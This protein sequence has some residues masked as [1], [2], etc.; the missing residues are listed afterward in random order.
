MSALPLKFSASFELLYDLQFGLYCSREWIAVQCLFWTGTFL[1]SVFQKELDCISLRMCLY[2]IGIPVHITSLT[3]TDRNGAKKSLHLLEGN[4]VR[5]YRIWVWN[6][7]RAQQKCVCMVTPLM[8]DTSLC[9]HSSDWGINAGLQ[10]MWLCNGKSCTD[11]LR[12]VR[13]NS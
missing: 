12:K 11:P 6:G 5:I 9:W 3:W 4:I 8:A 10:W 1:Y 13:K 7:S 2:C